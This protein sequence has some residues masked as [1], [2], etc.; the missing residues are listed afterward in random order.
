MRVPP[1]IG[2]AG[3]GASGWERESSA[4]TKSHP[5]TTAAAEAPGT[6][7]RNALFLVA[8]QAATTALAVVF[9][10]VLGRSLGAA[11][12]GVYYLVGT[13][14]AFAFVLAE[15]GQPLFVIRQA[16]RE[17]GRAGELLGTTLALR[18]ALG[19]LVV[20]PVG[21]MAWALGYAARTTWLA[22]LMILATLPLFLAQAYGMVFRARDRMGRDA[23][24]SVAY[25]AAALGLALPALALGAGIPGVVAA[26]AAA[27][28][29]ALAVAGWSYRRLGAPPLAYSAAG[30]RE[31]LAAG[32]PILAMTAAASVQPY[33]D[34][35]ILSR[36]APAAAVGW[37]GAARSIMGT[38]LAP[39]AILGAAAYPQ[40]ARVSGDAGALR[41][42]V[43]AALRPLL[44][45]GALAAVGT[46]LFAGTAIGLIYG[47]GGFGPAAAI[48]QVFAPGFFLL[49]IDIL[50]GNVIYAC[51]GGTAF[52]LAKVAS[53]GAGTALDVVL[54]PI[55]QRRYG[56]GGIGVVVAFALSELVVFAG[57]MLALRR[58]T[59]DRA[60]AL[61]VARALAAA[62]ATVAGY[63][64]LPP[65]PAWLGV[66]VCLAAFTGAALAAGLIGK[67]DLQGLPWRWRRPVPG[68]PAAASTRASTSRSHAGRTSAAGCAA[69][70][71]PPL[72]ASHSRPS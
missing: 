42:E 14:A 15:W 8:G 61:D 43:R 64:L 19:L 4:T 21:L 1:V 67:R 6:V 60:A 41:R 29:L 71:R 52:A 2:S 18:V 55:F 22:V 54:I 16:A 5:A 12:F 9:S 36:L 50:L 49:F 34:A 7:A 31:L 3:A 46:Y 23:A 32:A 26:Q 38:L 65:L 48:L 11:D 28:L 33:L 40:L 27:G 45:L 59:L 37:Y 58:G 72:R 39:A 56:N 53:V 10:A 35:V 47:E 13:M 24:I 25:K 63:R 30:S 70:S 17:P 44:F 51:G 66:P 62:A 68:P 20:V 69:P 57:A